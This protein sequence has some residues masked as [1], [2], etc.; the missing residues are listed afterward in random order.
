VFLILT[1]KTQIAEI[2]TANK[3]FSNM[4][5][6]HIT[7]KIP[8]DKRRIT[9]DK[10]TE[11]ETEQRRIV[12]QLAE[13]LQCH[14]D[15]ARQVLQ[16]TEYD[17]AAAVQLYQ[18]LAS[19]A[20]PTR[21]ATVSPAARYVP[22][23]RRCCRAMAPTFAGPRS[24]ASSGGRASAVDRRIRDEFERVESDFFDL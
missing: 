16:R 22:W 19:A 1:K 21:P 20:P 24:V 17:Y 18:D 11:R 15:D 8:I 23:G 5:H 6:G 12:K 13:E 3:L 2:K 10:A 4:I 7:L 9:V 14:I